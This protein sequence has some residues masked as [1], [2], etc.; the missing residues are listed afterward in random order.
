MNV[1]RS[2]K[3]FNEMRREKKELYLEITFS[4]P[5]YLDG[6]CAEIIGPAGISLGRVGVLHPDVIT[7]YGL[8]LPISVM[9]ITIE[10]FV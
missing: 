4:D 7:A 10:P 8:A 2:I 1:P 9:D 5:T 6:R 3:Q